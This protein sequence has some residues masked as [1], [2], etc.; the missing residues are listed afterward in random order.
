[1]SASRV[2][3]V[4]CSGTSSSWPALAIAQREIECGRQFSWLTPRATTTVICFTSQVTLETSDFSEIPVALPES[5]VYFIERLP[6]KLEKG[7]LRGPT[8]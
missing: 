7:V 3:I 6:K 8:L 1:M 5:G 4:S 2:D